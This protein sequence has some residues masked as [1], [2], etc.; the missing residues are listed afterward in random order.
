[1]RRPICPPLGP[2]IGNADEVNVST[3]ISPSPTGSTTWDRWA[4]WGVVGGV[5]TLVTS[6]VLFLILRPLGHGVFE[7][8]DLNVYRDAGQ[9]LL[10]GHSLYTTDP[11]ILPFTYPPFAAVVSVVFAVLPKKVAGFGW[12]LANIAMLLVIV[13]IAFR[14]ALDRMPR[15]AV[16][17]SW[18]VL[19]ATMF[20]VRPIN[21]TLDWGQINL[22][23]LLLVLLDGMGVTRVPRGFLVGVAAAIKLVPGIFLVYFAVTRQWKATITAA[24]SLAGCIVVTQLIAPASSWQYWTKTLFESNRIGNSRYYSNQSLLGMVQ[25]IVPGSWVPAV[26]GVLGLVIVVLGFRRVRQAYDAGDVLAALAITGLLGCLFSPISWFHHFVWVLPAL[27]VLVDD[28]RD[29]RRML[30]AAL[31]ALLVTTHLPYVGL[32]LIDAGGAVGALGWL[33]E[34]SLGLMAVALVLGL[35]FRNRRDRR[36]EPAEVDH[37]PVAVA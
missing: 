10:D 14:P 17:T 25:R 20:W 33:L 24:A 19:T 27:G 4:R 37:E 32:H 21:D 16:I 35:P 28:G 13:R 30:V 22:L 15:S 23:L 18:L 6:V 34:N 26:W 2:P 11:K 29:R 9:R 12:F 5:L 36:I 8:P 3:S 1:M 31:L 7:Y